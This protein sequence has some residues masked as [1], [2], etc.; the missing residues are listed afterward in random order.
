[1]DLSPFHTIVTGV[2]AYN[3]RA[4]LRTNQQRLLD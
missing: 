1:M 2:R 4:G 3:A